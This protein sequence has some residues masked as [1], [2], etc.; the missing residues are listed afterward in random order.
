MG[1]V[2]DIIPESRPRIQKSALY[3]YIQIDDIADGSAQPTAMRGWQLPSR[4]TQRAEPG[5]IFVGKIWSS[6]NKWF[7]ASGD[8]DTIVVSNGLHRLRLK[9]DKED[10][11]L[12]I[13]AGL[14]QEA[15]LIQARAGSTGSDGL[16][17]LSELDLL[18]IVLP[19]VMDRGARETIQYLA[20]T[21]L[22]GHSTVAN[23][24]KELGTQ[25]RLPQV[26]V[27]PRSSHWV[28]V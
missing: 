5:D 9:H 10:Y 6:I 11:L 13:L 8:C 20:D 28:Q 18:D 7:V 1:E 14:N 24:V 19:R 16:A 23:V 12:D 21:L 2:A 4:G 17:E 15:Y 25:A 27:I 26:D 3:R 22:A